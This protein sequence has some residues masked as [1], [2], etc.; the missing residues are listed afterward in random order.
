MTFGT[1]TLKV[2]STGDGVTELQRWL[3]GKGFLIALTS[4]TGTFDAATDQAVKA[5]QLSAGIGC[6]G[7]VGGGT[8]TA[9][10]AYT[11]DA[12]SGGWHPTAIRNVQQTAIGGSYTTTTR[13]GV[14]H[15]TEGSN[16]P[17]YPDPPHFTVGRNGGTVQL[18][19][20][21]PTTVAARALANPAGEPETNRFGAIQIEI[22]G[23]AKDSATMATADADKFRVLGEWMRWTEANAGVANVAN[24]VFDG[25]ASYGVNGTT[26]LSLEQWAAST[27][28][29]GH[30]HVPQNTHWD[31]G[32][33]DIAALLVVPAPVA[34]AQGFSTSTSVTAPTVRA[35]TRA[36]SNAFPSL[37]LA[38][39]PAGSPFFEVLLTTSAALFLPQNA[40]LRTTGNF[41]ASRQDG[42]TS[43]ADAYGRYIAPVSTISAFAQ[44]NPAGAQVFYTVVGYADLNGSNPVPA[45]PPEV[46]AAA[47]AGVPMMPGFRGHTATDSLGVPLSMLKP[48]VRTASLALGR[49]RVRSYDVPTVPTP[50]LRAADRVEGEDGYDLRNR[51]VSSALTPPPPPPPAPTPAP[52]S[53]NYD[54]GWGRWS[55]SGQQQ[56]R[57]LSGEDSTVP[58]ADE[59]D[60]LGW[61]GSP[62]AEESVPVGTVTRAAAPTLLPEHKRAVIEFYV[63]PDTDLYTATTADAEYAGGAGTDHP[64]YQRFHTGLGFGIVAFSQDTGDLGQLLT[65]MND[66]DAATFGLTFGPDQAELLAVTNR[67]GP[68]GKDLPETPG[69]SRSARVQP[70]AGTDLWMEPWL[71]RFLAAGAHVPFRG[72]QIELASGLFLD[73]LL[74]FA[75]DLGLATPRGLAILFDRAAHRGVVNAMTWV[76]ESIG[77]LQS[78]QLLQEALRAIGA[79][80]VEAFQRSQP[81]LLVDDQFGPLTHAALTG[82]LQAL[83]AAGGVSPVPLL[84]YQRSIAGLGTRA[85][86]Q[87]WGDRIVRLVGDAAVPDTFQSAVLVP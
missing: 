43:S 46:L 84:D 58:V 7:E 79:A 71:S 53:S 75:G 11:G 24:H 51:H 6:D 48:S 4:P 5:F 57:N 3:I 85:T 81:D 27:G 18:W 32:K 63:G 29:V 87:P 77:A 16:L 86:G 66:R 60:D 13:R 73:P 33:I 12:R 55:P 74:R 34:P 64:A 1:G 76:V 50:D 65:L 80:S 78:P 44:A 14:L 49:T 36:L 20:H 62:Y 30:Q 21:Y 35:T 40:P 2:G 15:T 26:R 42:L 68:L 8:R 25:D 41:Y 56:P 45:A 70:V 83:V 39:D 69:G 61:P 17:A 31:P 10:D 59:Y 54:D 9:A 52:L 38:V 67:P 23:F 82:M 28:W 47:A 22:I 72:A 37:T 19:Q